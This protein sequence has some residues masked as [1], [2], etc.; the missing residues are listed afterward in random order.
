MSAALEQMKATESNG[1]QSQ[2]PKGAIATTKVSSTQVDAVIRQDAQV[3]KQK[4]EKYVEQRDKFIQD[5]LGLVTIEA[6]DA[7]APFDY[8]DLFAS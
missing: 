4:V 3:V 6:E 7:D 1:Q 2:P 5:A 8:S